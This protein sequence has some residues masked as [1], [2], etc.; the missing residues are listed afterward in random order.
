MI[1]ILGGGPAGRTAAMKLGLAGE[2]VTLVERGGLGGQCL[3]HGCMVVCALN[4]V[5]RALHQARNLANLGILESV[6]SFS[7]P[8]TIRQMASVQAKIEKILDAET[9]SCGVSVVR[10]EGRVDGE[11]LFLDGERLE[12]SALIIATGSLPRIPSIPGV[13]TPGV[14]TAHTLTSMPALPD[15]ILVIGGGIMAAEFAFIF[16][17]WGVAVDLAVRSTFLREVPGALR[18]AARRELEGVTIHENCTVTRIDGERAVERATLRAGG[19]EQEIPCDA[20][21]LAAGLVPNSGMVSGVRK[22]RD[23]RIVVDRR[24][25]TSVP[26]VYA[27]GDVTGSPCLTP[28]ARMEGVVAASSILGEGLEM[29][30]AAIPQAIALAHEYAFVDGEAAEDEVAFS[31]PGPAGPGTFWEVPRGRTGMAEVIV[32]RESGRVGAVS[33]AGPAAGTV[34]AYMAFLMKRGVSVH[35]FS[36]FMEVHPSSDGVYPLMKFSAGRLGREGGGRKDE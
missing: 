2:D 36:R 4:D 33:A 31:S 6:P 5:A 10:G 9:R 32:S 13:Q 29:D 1:G 22:G 16:R 15:H 3:H 14:W 24:M 25:A 8:E 28:V 21:F 26:G 34:A 27:C 7:F 18:D 20:V 23:G 30:Y 12:T 19:K 35:D 11:S 17:E